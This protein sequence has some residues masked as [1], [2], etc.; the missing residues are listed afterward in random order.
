[1]ER[2]RQE[3]TRKYLVFD[4][5]TVPNDEAGWTPPEDNPGDFPPIPAHKIVSIGGMLIQLTPAGFGNQSDNKV[6]WLGNFGKPDDEISII[7]EFLKMIDAEQ[8]DLVSY[9]GRG[10]DLAVIEHRC[11]RFGLQ[12]T[13][14]FDWNLRN[15]Y[16]PD[17]HLDLLDQLT[18]Y[19]ASR[20]S[21]LA[22][23]CA[24]LGMP[25]KMDV[26][27]TQVSDMIKEGK[28]QEVD[29]YCMCDVVETAWLLVRF[30]H[31][32]GTI[33][34]ETN[35]N[36]IHNIAI[37]AID[38]GNEMLAKLVG[39]TNLNRLDLEEL[40]EYSDKRGTTIEEDD[41]DD[42]DDGLPF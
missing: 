3:M 27:G 42:D 14:L 28:Q 17:G 30:M 16:K 19:G 23:V 20:R 9:N 5:E 4:I 18:N 40:L 41:D 33:N 38:T 34:T 31:M 7:H 10:F 11:M 25:G 1:M 36:S 8:P 37:A 29:S 22:H 12:C 6:L 39:L 13:S 21:S 32:K 2:V 15:R 24:A 35:Y 26:D